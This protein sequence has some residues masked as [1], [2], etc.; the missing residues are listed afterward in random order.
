MLTELNS[1]LLSYEQLF[2]EVEKEK[3]LIPDI[4]RLE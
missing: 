1:P 4:L 3:I 2:K